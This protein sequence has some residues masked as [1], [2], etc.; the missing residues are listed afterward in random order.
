MAANYKITHQQPIT[1]SQ[2]GGMFVPGME[3]TFTTIPHDVVGKVVI[4]TAQ[5]TKENVDRVVSAQATT[6]EDVQAL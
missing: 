6:I 2:P 1:T 3:I 4:P 5:Y